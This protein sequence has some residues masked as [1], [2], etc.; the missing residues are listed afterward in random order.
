MSHQVS[1]AE[2]TTI[3][4]KLKLCC[5]FYV[6]HLLF[7]YCDDCSNIF[8]TTASLLH[9][10]SYHALSLAAE[11]VVRF[12]LRLCAVKNS[13]AILLFSLFLCYLQNIHTTKTSLIAF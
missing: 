5:Q 2:L 11:D 3:R 12:Y 13:D 6:F 4:L 8:Q 10:Y 1:G 9:C 7:K